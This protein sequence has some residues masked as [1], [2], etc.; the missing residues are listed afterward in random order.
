MK[1]N[2]KAFNALFDLRTEVCTGTLSILQK[3]W[4]TAK[5]FLNSNNA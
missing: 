5:K 4:D 3:T 2:S 1:Q